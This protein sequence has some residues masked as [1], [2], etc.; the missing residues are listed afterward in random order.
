MVAHDYFKVDLDI[1]WETIKND[2]PGMRRDVQALLD[3]L[4]G[5][6]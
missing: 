2:L 6:Q 1:V 5:E 4:A 3:R